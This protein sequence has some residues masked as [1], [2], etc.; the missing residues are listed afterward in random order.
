MSTAGAVAQ[1]GREHESDKVV[2]ATNLPGGV[3]KAAWVVSLFLLV[4]PPVAII[5]TY[6]TNNVVLLSVPLL[7]MAVCGAFGMRLSI[8]LERTE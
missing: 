1:P 3:E 6:I 8:Y 7:L 4:F 2:A 5:G